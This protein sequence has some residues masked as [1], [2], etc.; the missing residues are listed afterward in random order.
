[1]DAEILPHDEPQPT[2]DAPAL[3]QAD[4]ELQ[5]ASVLGQLLAPPPRQSISMS[6]TS[7]KFKTPV[8]QR[9]YADMFFGGLESQFDFH[10][11]DDEFARYSMLV[12]ALDYKQMDEKSSAL[13]RK[14]PAATPY[15][16]LKEAILESIKPTD[17][18]QTKALLMKE[19]L[20]DGKPSDFLARLTRIADPDGNKNPVVV[21]D[22]KEIWIHALPVAWHNT[23]LAISDMTEAGMKADVLSRWQHTPTQTASYREAIGVDVSMPVAAVSN[24]FL[25]PAPQVAAV[26]DHLDLA[27]RMTRMENSLADLSIAL[28]GSRNN[29]SNNQR[30]RSNNNNNNNNNN[31]TS[32]G[33]QGKKGKG[34]QATRDRSQSPARLNN[35]LCYAHNKYGDDAYTCRDYCTQWNTFQAQKGS[36]SEASN[37][38]G[39]P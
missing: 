1:M 11:V 4:F 17:Y 39:R 22:V 12:G 21:S 27:S 26:A 16:S 35:G 37:F 14:R 6:T 24:P 7:N 30:G 34:F 28:L 29:N 31:N 38:Q 25:L 3:S 33:G 19:K 8:F 10:K 23:L 36:N 18:S 9:E 13:I 5:F 20:N 32:G 15:S 2:Q